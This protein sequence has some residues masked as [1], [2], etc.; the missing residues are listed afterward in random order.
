SRQI[1]RKTSR[2]MV[3]RITVRN[4]EL[5][6]VL[7]QDTMDVVYIL[8]DRNLLI[9]RDDSIKYKVA[10]HE[11]LLFSCQNRVFSHDSTPRSIT[12]IYNNNLL[13]NF[14]DP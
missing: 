13:V 8:V 4:P 12:G 11:A 2:R 3:V 6:G 5:V 1:Q 10:L 9:V 14:H 7:A